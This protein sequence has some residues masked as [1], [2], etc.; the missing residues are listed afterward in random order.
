M[1]FGMRKRVLHLAIIGSLVSAPV[2]FAANKNQKVEEPLRLSQDREQLIQTLTEDKASSELNPMTADE[3]RRLK[4]DTLIIKEAQEEQAFDPE[5]MFRTINVKPNN[6]TELRDIYLSPN[7]ATTLIFL[8][9]RGNYWPIDSYVL[10]LSEDVISRD[11]INTGT[12]VL[13]P[14]Q[15]S[16]KGN[17]VVMLKDSKLPLMLTLNV[18]T[19]KVDYKAELRIDDYGPDSQV[20]AFDT[21]MNPKHT[22]NLSS[23]SKFS[24]NDR[25]DLLNGITPDNYK[26]RET[27]NSAVESWTN[28]KVL[29]IKTREQL[30]TP[31]L[32]KDDEYNMMKGADGSYLYTVSFVP[33]ILLYVGGNAVPVRIK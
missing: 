24:K 7:Y 30:L 25:L 33:E 12:L 20:V 4:K 1:E 27:S 8:D 13:T 17:L 32:L 6:A 19:K 14:K 22:M 23:M 16:T 18:N 3:I 26:K 21:N 29:F 15:Y 2:S 10:P 11:V 31:R 9:K 5:V 28:G